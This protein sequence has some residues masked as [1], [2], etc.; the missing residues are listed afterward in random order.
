M[1]EP[2]GG[3]LHDSTRGRQAYLRNQSLPLMEKLSPTAERDS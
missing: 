3:G 1:D 2:I